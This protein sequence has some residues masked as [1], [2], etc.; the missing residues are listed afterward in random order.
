MLPP[1]VCYD[2]ACPVNPS[3]NYAAQADIESADGGQQQQA[4]LSTNDIVINKLTQILSYLRAGTRNKKKKKE[5]LLSAMRG[6][7]ELV[8][9]ELISLRDENKR[10]KDKV[11]T[12]QAVL[13]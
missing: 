6:R 10:A 5:K 1:S 3:C 12:W 2:L 9:Q 7:D 11:G 4:T 13:I 8:Q